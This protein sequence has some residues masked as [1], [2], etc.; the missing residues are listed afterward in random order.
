MRNFAD[1]EGFV[2]DALRSFGREFSIGAALF[3]F[4]GGEGGYSGSIPSEHHHI[5]DA[6]LDSFNH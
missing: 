1:V 6:H 5:S 4:G 2:S 3:S